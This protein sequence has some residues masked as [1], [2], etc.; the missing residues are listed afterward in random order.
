VQP[1]NRVSIVAGTRA[2]WTLADLG[3]LCA[4]AVVAPR[5]LT[6]THTAKRAIVYAKFK[7]V[8]D[9]M[10]GGSAIVI[11]TTRPSGTSGVVCVPRY[12]ISPRSV[13]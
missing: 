13:L 9:A 5:E 7:D 6:P 4:G 10:N 2:E 12:S 3:A 8:I 11:R 1:G